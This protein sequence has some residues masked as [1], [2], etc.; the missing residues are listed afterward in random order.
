[1]NKPTFLLSNI[2]RKG[3]YLCKYVPEQ[4]QPDNNNKKTLPLEIHHDNATATATGFQFD[5]L[6]L[7]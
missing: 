7:D 3:Y 2:W 6:P 5:Y 4:T 1:M